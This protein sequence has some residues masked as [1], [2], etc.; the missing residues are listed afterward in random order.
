MAVVNEKEASG[1]NHLIGRDDELFT[2][3]WRLETGGKHSGETSP[4]TGKT[5]VADAF[6]RTEKAESFNCLINR[7]GRAGLS[8]TQCFETFHCHWVTN[9]K[10]NLCFCFGSRQSLLMAGRQSLIPRCS[11]QRDRFLIFNHSFS[12]IFILWKA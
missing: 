12:G 1:G 7:K 9:P 3:Q 10:I 2:R 6:P 8:R 11:Q 4:I 5:G